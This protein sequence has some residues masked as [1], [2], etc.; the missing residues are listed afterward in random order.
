MD[1]NN[2]TNDVQETPEQLMPPPAINGA[3]SMSNG[4][5]DGA[6]TN[7]AVND[8]MQ[9]QLQNQ[10]LA[11]AQSESQSISAGRNSLSISITIH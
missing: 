9:N 2:N 6:P 11:D 3:A 8:Q 7:H 5:S 4:Q 1:T 10:P